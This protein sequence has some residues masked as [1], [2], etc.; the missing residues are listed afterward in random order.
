MKKIFAVLLAAVMLLSS[1]MI[2]VSAETVGSWADN[3]SLKWYEDAI[4]AD[5]NATTFT[6]KTASDLAGLAKLVDGGNTFAGKTIHVDANE[7]DLSAHYWNPIGNNGKPFQGVFDGNGVTIRGM[8]IMETADADQQGLFAVLSATGTTAPHP[9]IRNFSL[10]DSSVTVSTSQK[11]ALVVG[12]L[13]T[14]QSVTLTVENIYAQGTVQTATNYGKEVYAGGICGIVFHNGENATGALSLFQNVICDV[15]VTVTSTKASYA[16]GILGGVNNSSVGT[17]RLENCI[18]QGDVCGGNADLTGGLVGLNN[19][20]GSFEYINCLNQGAV[21]GKAGSLLAH[22]GKAV[23]SHI[24]MNCLHDGAA[25]LPVIG[26]DGTLTAET[27]ATVL[28][29]NNYYVG[30]TEDGEYYAAIGADQI[31]VFSNVLTVASTLTDYK[32]VDKTL[33]GVISACNA[34]A[35]TDGL[36]A[37]QLSTPNTGDTYSVRFISKL[38]DA[39]KYARAGFEITVGETTKTMLTDTVYREI[40]ATDQYGIAKAYGAETLGAESLFAAGVYDIP[41]SAETVVIKVTSFTTVS[42]DKDAVRIYD[43]T[44]EITLSHGALVGYEKQIPT[45]GGG[46]LAGVNDAAYGQTLYRYTETNAEEYAAYCQKLEAQGF[47]KQLSNA[48]ADNLY[49]TYVKGDTVQHVYY[50]GA[51]NEVRLITGSIDKTGSVQD[52]VT[53]DPKVTDFSVIQMNLTYPKSSSGGMGYIITLEDGRFVIVD[54]GNEIAE[55]ADRLYKIL[56][57]YNKRN[58]GIKIAGWI[59]THEHSDHYGLFKS[60]VGRYGDDVEIQN[61]YVSI[62]SAGYRVGS[63]NPSNFMWD[64]FDALAEQVGGIP[65]KV[66]HTGQKFMISNAEFEILYTTED[67]YPTPLTVFNDASVVFR[68]KANG[69]SVLFLGDAAEDTSN[70]LTSMYGAYLKSDVVQ[71]AHHGWNGVTTAV[72]EAIAPDIAMWPN[73]QR[74]YNGCM[75]KTEN[76]FY[77]TDVDLVAAVGEENVYIAEG[78]CYRFLFSETEITVERFD[79]DATS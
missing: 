53:N 74:E 7:I 51:K 3:A 57:K 32:N 63:G 68:V 5:A 13:Y 40:S 22:I 58:D 64:E 67:L 8:K 4:A 70:V 54:G 61:F 44:Y 31:N 76:S 62:P 69:K 55:D 45:Y 59:L 46:K 56:Q 15:D 20:I 71:V 66:L 43:D 36:C 37:L 1:A 11:P 34:I 65:V 2:C 10:V 6:V 52:D 24:I 26:T 77:Q 38:T 78:D 50:V 19:G 41:V 12:Q 14:N 29:S 16:G 42:D 25:E 60:F 28:A 35:K 27:P 79:A 49:A 48:N 23:S 33:A 75:T 18:N 72:Y 73:S 17:L 30:A 39:K 47:V 21:T 9:A